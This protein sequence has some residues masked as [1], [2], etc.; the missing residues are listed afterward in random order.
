MEKLLSVLSILIILQ[1]GNSALNLREK[2]LS[3][4]RPK[5]SQY[6]IETP[7]NITVTEGDSITLRCKVG[8]LAGKVQWTA[9]GFALGHL[10]NQ[11]KG[12]CPACTSS[13][14]T[15]K[16]E[17][18]LQVDDIRLGAYTEGFEC[19]VGPKQQHKE[20]RARAFVNVLVPPETL[21]L[22]NTEPT[23]EMAA[24]TM[25]E[26]SCRTRGAKPR[27]KIFWFHGRNRIL[28][29][30]KTSQT[31]RG[32]REGTWDFTETLKFKAKAKDD[33]TK[34][35]CVVQHDALQNRKMEQEINLVVYYPPGKPKILGDTQQTYIQGDIIEVTCSSS[36]GNPP[37]Y[38]SWYK[39]GQPLNFPYTMQD[40]ST[41]IST[42]S[43][44][45]EP[46]LLTEQFSCRAG[47]RETQPSLTSRSI[48]FNVTFSSEDIHIHGPD[49]ANLG[50]EIQLTCTSEESN[51]PS[52]IIWDIDGRVVNIQTPQEHV[53]ASGG[54][55]KTIS[56]LL[57]RVDVNLS[58]MKVTCK[59]V[60][61]IFDGVIAKSK[62]IRILRPPEAPSISGLPPTSLREGDRLTLSCIARHGSPLPNLV[63]YKKGEK[64]VRQNYTMIPGSHSI[65]YMTIKVSRSD[66]DVKY[67]CEANN[68]EHFPTV[69]Q[70]TNFSVY[71]EPL[72]A[73]LY[74]S[75]TAEGPEVY[76]SRA[77]DNLRLVCQSGN[78]NPAAKITWFKNGK[79]VRGGEYRDR[80]D[81]YGGV[82]RSQEMLINEGNP[83]TSADDDTK[84]ACTISNPAING[85]N[86]TREYTL[87]VF[88][89][90]EFYENSMSNYSV[91][92]GGTV[93]MTVATRANPHVS[94]YLWYM[95]DQ[96]NKPH[97][98]Q[99]L[100]PRFS[101]LDQSLTIKDVRREDSGLYIFGADNEIGETRKELRLDVLYHPR[102]I[103]LTEQ[104]VVNEG[105][106]AVFHC[107]VDANPINANTVT[108][109]VGRRQGKDFSLEDRG[110]LFS[111]DGKKTFTLTLPSVQ[112]TDRGRFYCL[113]SNQLENSE[114]DKKETVLKVNF[115]PEIRKFP[116]YAKF[117]QN[118]MHQ[119]DIECIA[120]GYPSVKIFWKKVG[121]LGGLQDERFI[122]DRSGKSDQVDYGTWKSQLTIQ[123]VNKGDYT[124]YECIAENKLGEDRHNISLRMPSTPDPPTNLLVTKLDYQTVQLEWEPGFNGGFTQSFI[125]KVVKV[126][127]GLV[128]IDEVKAPQLERD[129]QFI[130]QTIKLET[131]AEYVFSVMARNVQ[132]QSEFSN[133][134]HKSLRDAEN[135][136]TEDNR[137]PR[138]IIVAVVLGCILCVILLLMIITCCVKQRKEIRRRDDKQTERSSSVS[139]KRSI[140]I[141]KYA[142]SKYTTNFGADM[143]ISPPSNSGSS[144]CGTPD[145]QDFKYLS[146][147]LSMPGHDNDDIDRGYT[148]YAGS[149]SVHGG[150]LKRGNSHHVSSGI[151]TTMEDDGFDDYLHKNGGIGY[152]AD[153]L[154]KGGGGGRNRAGSLSSPSTH[155]QPPLGPHLGVSGLYTNHMERRAG[156]RKY[157]GGSI[158]PPPDIP[159]PPPPVSTSTLDRLKKK[160]LGGMPP[161]PIPS[162][163]CNGHIASG[164]ANQ[165]SIKLV[166][167]ELEKLEVKSAVEISNE[168]SKRI[169]DLG[170]DRTLDPPD[171]MSHLQLQNLPPMFSS[172][173]PVPIP[174]NR[175]QNNFTHPSNPHYQNV[176]QSAETKLFPPPPLNQDS[177]NFM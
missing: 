23:V 14:D 75:R 164:S 115:T 155:T 111:Y 114:P 73:K 134:E 55:W 40:N 172:S 5:N 43:L 119:I 25:K 15:N 28:D 173:Q 108:W 176:L 113:A 102:I 34:V 77:G 39:N 32:S 175:H 70:T 95:G 62:S 18:H 19:Q 156:I 98:A 10:P 117:A 57:Q 91:L 132:G 166:P 71:F 48:K 37:P 92:E 83:V 110:A 53:A 133:E 79:E 61:N 29:Q 52:T 76:K 126:Q 50:T 152:Q 6:F 17:F 90:P 135:V 20:I 136:K 33:G 51:P 31:V 161:I 112:K 150:T 151:D 127:T 11:I 81:Q 56:T 165:N 104:I 86:I 69:S 128:S 8:N 107:I 24:G 123:Y 96:P 171:T 118:L 121:N 148:S 170:L 82:R 80:P 140:I 30:E 103:N 143:F 137:V 22:F 105:D 54:G 41:T 97:P 94:H 130:Y 84:F 12:A 85:Q 163:K 159:S 144:F 78:S 122:W 145:P 58:E 106:Q 16:N 154:L 63:W 3:L 26:M 124:T 13:G 125:T 157:S 158:S 68:Q 99:S 87:T 169:N 177:S 36:G 1:N 45:A 47:N 49:Q 4:A 9:N 101:T 27:A 67:R 38:V 88:Y 64:I 42:L 146:R 100:P 162:T 116:R 167:P 7:K 66:N 44:R 139:S 93:T 2:D 120:Y 72:E 147:S 109:T 174:F 60:N 46:N 131:N 141:D 21:E 168:L 149:C 65:A 138:V 74:L 89:P 153:K 129:E 59:A 35:R 160:N 142:S